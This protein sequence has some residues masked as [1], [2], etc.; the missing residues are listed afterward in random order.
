MK[1]LV[2]LKYGPFD[3]ED[4]VSIPELREAFCND[5]WQRLVY[6]IDAVMHH[7]E[8]VTVGD[9][10]ERNIIN[11]S[12]VKLEND[13]IYGKEKCCAYNRGGQFLAVLC[14]DSE[15]GRWQPQK[16]FYQII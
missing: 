4:A 11:G 10:Q 12:S 5:D 15:T 6:P 16:V 8:V 7:W 3:I 2:R 13:A 14:F 1:G 9:V